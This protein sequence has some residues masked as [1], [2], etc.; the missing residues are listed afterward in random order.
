MGVLD[1]RGPVIRKALAADLGSISAQT[2]LQTLAGLAVP[3][4][5]SATE[6]WRLFILLRLNAAN[7]TMDA[8]F[9]FSVPAAATMKWGTTGGVVAGWGGVLSGSTP[10]AL[11]AESDTVAIGSPANADFGL[12]L[13]AI[14]FGGG[15]SGNVQLQ[16]A[17]NT[18][19]AGNLQVLKGSCVE[20]I[21]LG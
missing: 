3:I 12:A 21:H 7:I 8:K 2:T 9:G 17:Q 19:D 6:M 20:A 18:S 15:I 13:N 1:T 16:Y 14:V 10:A 4:G 5:A 11:L